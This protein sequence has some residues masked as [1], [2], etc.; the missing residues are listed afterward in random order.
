MATRQFEFSNRI[1]SLTAVLKRILK[2]INDTSPTET[3]VAAL[4]FKAKIIII[5]LL[6]NSLKHSNSE[7]TLIHVNM[8]EKGLIITKLDNGNPLS[9]LADTNSSQQKIP[10]SNDILHTLYARSKMKDQ[11]HFSYEENKMNDIVKTNDIVEHFGLL[12]ITKA[13][14]EFIYTYSHQTKENAFIVTINF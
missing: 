4:L 5:E 12:I 1:D 11:I 3:E 6:T 10:V 13:A 8:D 2:F 14:D 9:L 7:S